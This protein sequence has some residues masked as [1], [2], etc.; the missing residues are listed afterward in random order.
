MNNT[1]RAVNRLLLLVIGVVLLGLGAAVIAV[2]VW[3]RAADMWTDTARAAEGWLGQALE[4]TRIGAT[5]L[6][7]V[8]VGILAALVLLVILLIVAL[9]R[10][11][12]R[13]SHAVLRSAGQENPLGRVTVK[14]SFASDALKNSL[15][16]RGDILSTHVSAND[17]RRESVMHVSITPRQNT[18][19]RDVIEHVDRLVTNLATLTGR[20]LPT[21]ISI[22]SGLRARLAADQS[23]LS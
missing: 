13:R 20:D 4:T 8:A 14:E 5:A 11:G 1:N 10:I 17:I 12:G 16:A 22:H 7:W 18:S 19:P 23:R 9:A 3:P 15:D 2:G 6:T 21:Y